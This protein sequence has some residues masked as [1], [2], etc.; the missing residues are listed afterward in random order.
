MSF[1]TVRYY[2]NICVHFAVSIQVLPFS[3]RRLINRRTNGKEMNRKKE[4]K[5]RLGGR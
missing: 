5:E 4:K 3:A 2:G 1:F